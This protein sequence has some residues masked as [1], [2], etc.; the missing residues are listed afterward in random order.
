MMFKLRALRRVT[1]ERDMSGVSRETPL[2]SRSAVVFPAGRHAVTITGGAWP[3]PGPTPPR[4]RGART[5]VAVP[6]QASGRLRRLSNTGAVTA[7]P[8]PEAYVNGRV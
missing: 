2:R 7:W 3:E 6:A 5:G 1:V 4:R 8:A